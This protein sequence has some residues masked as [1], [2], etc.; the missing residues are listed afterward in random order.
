M[1]LSD[2]FRLNPVTA[3]AEDTARDAAKQ[4]KLQRVGSLA[5]VNDKGRPVGM[6]TDRDIIQHV[7][8]RRK[9]PDAVTLADIMNPDVVS[10]SQNAPVERAFHRMRQ[11]GVR[12]VMVTDDNGALVGILT[13][14]DALPLIADQFALAASVVK[15]QF[16]ASAGESPETA[17]AE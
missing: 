16:P 13:Y 2:Y 9:D 17:S 11:E 3:R 7:L 1:A 6:V 10:I 4:M 14:D 15:A 5:V 12:R 8:R